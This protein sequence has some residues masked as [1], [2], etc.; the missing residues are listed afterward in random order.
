MNKKKSI[1]LTFILLIV[2]GLST[3]AAAAPDGDTEPV[4]KIGDVEY[5]T[6][7]DALKAVQDGDVIYLLADADAS[8]VAF[9][10]CNG[11]MVIIT[12]TTGNEV[13]NMGDGHKGGIQ[14]A[15]ITFLNLKM[16]IRHTLTS[17]IWYTEGMYHAKKIKYENVVFDGVISTYN[18]VDFLNC[19]FTSNPQNME[20]TTWNYGGTQIF[21]GCKFEAA[22]AGTKSFIKL[23]N[24]GAP[25]SVAVVDCEF[26][27][28]ANPDDKEWKG[29][30]VYNSNPAA[31]SSKAKQC[32]KGNKVDGVATDNIV[33]YSEGGANVPRFDSPEA[34]GIT[35]PT[36]TIAKIGNKVYASLADAVTAV[37][38]GETITMIQDVDN[39][40][41]IIVPSGKNFT[42]N[43]EGHTY[44]VTDNL[45]GST[46][47]KNQ[48]FQLLKG[49][50]LIFKNGTITTNCAKLG[51]NSYANLKL[52]D[53]TIDMSQTSK[54][55]QVACL[56]TC[57]GNVSLQ[58]NTNLKTKNGQIAVL[59]LYWPNGEYGD[60]NVE[61]NTTGEVRG[62]MA[63]GS[64][65]VQDLSTVAQ[66]SHVAIKNGKYDVTFDMD[67]L[68][69]YDFKIFGGIFKTKPDANY[70]AEGKAVIDNPDETT[71]SDYPFAVANAPVAKI[72]ETTYAS[73]AEAIAAVKNGETITMIA[74]EVLTKGQTITLENNEQFTLD[75]NG[76]TISIA[77]TGFDFTANGTNVALRNGVPVR[78]AIVVNGNGT[79]NICDNSTEKLG[80]IETKNHSYGTTKT[81]LVDGNAIVNVNS[82]TIAADYAPFYVIGFTGL[83]AVPEDAPKPTL[84]VNGG[85]IVGQQIGIGIKGNTATLKVVGGEIVG[86]EYYAVSTNG[87]QDWYDGGKFAIEIT[88]GSIKSVNGNAM[89]L[90]AEGPTVITG[91]TIEGATGIAVKG[92][93]L[94]ISNDAVV[95]ATGP[96]AEAKDVSSG[97]ANTGSAVYVEDTYT[98]HAPI[99]NISGGKFSSVNNK[100]VEYFTTKAVGAP[101]KGKITVYAGLYDDDS[102]KDYLAEGKTVIDNPDEATKVEYPYAVANEIVAKIGNVEYASLAEAIAAVKD[103]ETITMIQDVKKAAGISVPSGKNFTVDFG[104]HKYAMECPGA[105]SAATKTSGFQLLKNSN[106]VFKNGTI[107]CTEAN[108]DKTWTS[109]SESKGIAMIIQNYANLT[110]EDMTI[111]AT[112]IAH[113]G[114]AVR[115][116]LSNNSGNVEYKG[117]TTI[118]TVGNDYAFDVCKYDTYDAPTVK[119]NSTGT[120][121]GGIELSGG[122]FVVAQN[123]AVSVPVMAAEGESTLEIGEGATLSSSAN[124]ND[125]NPNLGNGHTTGPVQVKQGAGLTISGAGTIEGKN[126]AYSAVI[127]SINGDDDSKTAKLTVNGNVTLQGEYYGI[128]GNGQRH[129]TEIVVNGG[130]IKGVH[131]QDNVG[132][133]HPQAGKLTIN[134]GAIEGYSSAVE[135]R[136]GSITVTGGSLT[137]TATKFKCNP[138][139]SGNTTEGAALAIAQ[140]NTKKDISVLIS[141]G[142]FTGV[143]ALNECNPQENDPAPQVTMNVSGGKFK[144]EVSTVDVKN[145][146][147][148]GIYS[149]QP[150]AAEYLAIGKTIID[151]PDEATKGDYPYAVVP[152]ADE[153]QVAPN[154]EI[155]PAEGEQP[156]TDDE[157][158]KAKEAVS[159]AITDM[160]GNESAKLPK[161]TKQSN[162][163]AVDESVLTTDQSVGIN[164]EFDGV[165]VKVETESVSLKEFTFDVTPYVVEKV[166]EGE[167]EKSVSIKKIENKD[168]KAPMTFRLPIPSNVED[169]CARVIHHKENGEDENMG[170]YSIT[171]NEEEKYIEI[172]TPS[173]SKFDIV[174]ENV[175][176]PNKL[177][178]YAGGSELIETI[179]P[180]AFLNAKATNPNAIAF[181]ESTYASWAEEQTNVVVDYGERE[182]NDPRYVCPKFVLIDLEDF[183]SPVDFVA[184]TGYYTRTN[185]Q[186]LNSVCLPFA[187]T[188]ANVNNGKIGTYK[189]S[190]INNG[191][192]TITFNDVESV[193]AGVPCIV[194]CESN[195]NWVITF[196]ETPIV[197]EPNNTDNN[198]IKGTYIKTELSEGYFKVSSDGTKFVNTVAG[199]SHA[200]P[201]RAYLDLTTQAGAKELTIEW[202]EGSTTGIEEVQSSRFKVQGSVYNLNGMRVNPST[203]SGQ[204][205]KGI[206]IMNGKKYIK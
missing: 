94:S 1:L 93:S 54:T 97:N 42:L 44:N 196:N 113:N 26:V 145:F 112:N 169:N 91:G 89:Y 90:P 77:E 146:L 192:G 163:E 17:G 203:G 20:Y 201:F 185:T 75:L 86:N 186:G 117:N 40:D 39:A 29:C 194:D 58:G 28:P 66:H 179:D 3:L 23:F 60:I 128:V 30:Q 170:L 5:A 140:H 191:T 35:L 143:K 190:N 41:G 84:N 149:L 22:S 127:V 177:N 147:A 34:M 12:G 132:I 154:L 182:T 206:V 161:E 171:E 114:A 118:T 76:K 121:N 123:L 45:A 184:E 205:N 131:S 48:C 27:N 139:G 151:N 64:Y 125:P 162:T 158:T 10:P 21:K 122:N 195:E 19:T 59:A 8:S 4:A 15:D 168:I 80:K 74:N 24:Q 16:K 155:A 199:T 197:A 204:A 188:Q 98:N 133:F 53:M 18:D 136:G 160:S 37:Q 152:L 157:K 71:K 36:P 38:N 183:Y 120:V 193:A 67:G 70:L 46:G 96:Y 153:V 55:G 33:K 138:N 13:L 172:S 164:V 32:V 134:G 56:E 2:G 200:W 103:G 176:A 181:V 7:D 167:V 159:D 73:L 137:S 31:V 135:I 119:W 11:K 148:G 47:T 49:S 85:K 187:I 106:I 173:F 100:A 130:T 14:D 25:A 61:L 124:F 92:G 72:G 99:V 102:A 43:F 144:G 87:T 82:G 50:E 101:D 105:G 202:N 108:K 65:E 57:N 81:I 180:N 189:S 156:L 142:E 198:P 51:V 88:G 115:Y 95:K 116:A 9:T 129:N 104:G 110:L 109:T 141:G 6:F 150:G 52:V 126:N 175:V 174:L 69:K 166:M 107:E 78:F 178:Y 111:D 165:K 83:T 79:M 62:L 68:E 63:Y